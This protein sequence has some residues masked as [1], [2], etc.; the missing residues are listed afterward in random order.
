M[1]EFDGKNHSIPT[2]LERL[3]FD[4]PVVIG[5]TGQ[6]LFLIA[7]ALLVLCLIF[8]FPVLG[9]LTGLWIPMF[10]LSCI[11]SLMLITVAGKRIAKQ[12]EQKPADIVWVD[13]KI[14]LSKL[15]GFKTIYFINKET[16]SCDRARIK[17]EKTIKTPKITKG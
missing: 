3:D 5:L 14:A 6:E 7:G 10:G 13:Y 8:V 1:N 12:K 11:I 4:P 15:F 9:M 16:W 17:K 2:T